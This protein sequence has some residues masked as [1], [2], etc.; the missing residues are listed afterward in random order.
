VEWK[1]KKSHTVLRAASKVFSSG[2][3]E[4]RRWRGR[5][6]TNPRSKGSEEGGIIRSVYSTA[7]K[8]SK[9]MANKQGTQWNLATFATSSAVHV[10]KDARFSFLTTMSATAAGAVTPLVLRL[11]DRVASIGVRNDGRDGE[12]HCG[13]NVGCG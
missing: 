10:M 12:T 8:K 7:M 5:V 3:C 6:A 4:S 13:E 9:P 11:L 2:D 1:K